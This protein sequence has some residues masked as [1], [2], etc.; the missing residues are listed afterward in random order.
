MMNKNQYTNANKAGSMNAHA[1][2]RSAFL[3]RPRTSLSYKIPHQK[4]IGVEFS[5]QMKKEQ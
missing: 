1:Y 3:Y 2:P 5:E 4:S